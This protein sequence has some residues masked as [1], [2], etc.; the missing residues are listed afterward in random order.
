MAAGTMA[1]AREAK[2]HMA[3]AEKALKTSWIGLK[4]A[5]DHLSAS[6]EFANAATKFRSANMMEYA[7]AAWVRS[8]E[9]KEKLSDLFGA[10]RAYESAGA[11]CDGTGPGGPKA[12]AKN[13]E[14]AIRCFR[15][16]AK[17]DI[18]AKLILKRAESLEKDGDVDGAKVAF[19][20]AIEVF[21][22][23][24]KDYQLGDV[25]KQYI[26]FLVRSN[27]VDDTA[28]A[29]DGHVEI[30]VRNKHYPFAHKELLAKA[31]LFLSVQDVVRAD[32]ALQP[33][34]A[35]EGWFMSKESQVG[36]E[37]VEAFQAHDAENAE[38]LLKEQ[39]FTFL[40]V[41]VARL[42]KKLK[43]PDFGAQ[44]AAGSAGVAATSGARATAAAPVAAE[45]VT[46][47]DMAEMLM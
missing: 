14:K 6:M 33:G 45:P 21:K 4:F 35:V 20:E 16:C 30:L 10:G 3:L 32:Q 12:A 28:K 26:G 1:A 42:A 9:M 7:V 2:E 11:I 47:A 23:D 24:E 17:G 41:E 31:V 22:E 13:W 38:R 34:I 29:M 8:A 36:S 27:R 5:P 15:L 25:Y 39:V 40:Q 43:V 19:E 44:A 37:L 46:A 18:A